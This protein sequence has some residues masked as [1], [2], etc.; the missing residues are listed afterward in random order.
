[1]LHPGQTVFNTKHTVKYHDQWLLDVFVK[2][3]F[4]AMGNTVVEGSKINFHCIRL[5]HVD[6]NLSM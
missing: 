1:M 2:M 6:S 3:T 4:S 5:F